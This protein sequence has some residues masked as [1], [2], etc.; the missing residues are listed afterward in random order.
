MRFRIPI[1]RWAN[2]H[3]DDTGPRRLDQAD[4]KV[5]PEAT[6]IVRPD[7]LS[8]RGM[9]SG[10]HPPDP[11]RGSA[12]VINE[13]ERLYAANGLDEFTADTLDGPI[14]TSR[15]VWNA[16]VDQLL[17]AQIVT[18]MHLGAQE[19]ENVVACMLRVQRLRGVVA[20]LTVEVENWRS[21]LR[22]EIEHLPFPPRV[23]PATEDAMIHP[24]TIPDQPGTPSVGRVVW[25]RLADA[26]QSAS[27]GADQPD[28]RAF[29]QALPF[30]QDPA[31]GSAS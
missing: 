8:P 9:P 1:W 26:D 5:R 29:L 2:R 30:D 27:P 21:V 17:P 14:E 11:A 25:E 12:W 7:S 20:E 19:E 23:V 18:A 10:T 4:T 28:P 31:V 15:R 22:G 24:L 13:I 3:T 6:H 16:H